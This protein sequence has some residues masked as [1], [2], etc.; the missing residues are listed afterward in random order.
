[1]PICYNIQPLPP[2]KT[3]IFKHLCVYVFIVIYNIY[4]LQHIWVCFNIS[5]ASFLGGFSY[6]SE[7]HTE[8]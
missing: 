7:S 5:K 8:A 3:Y 2:Q 4:V 6:F 1:M